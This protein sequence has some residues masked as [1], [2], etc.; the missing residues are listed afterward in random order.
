MKTSSAK[1]KGRKH[2]Q[3][4]RDEILKRHP[5]LDET[6]V[7]SVSMGAGGE[8]ILLSQAARKFLPVS[9]ECKHRANYAFYKD[10]DQ[11]FSNCPENCEPLLVVRANHRPAVAIIDFE[12]FL[13]HYQPRKVRSRK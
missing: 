4:V 10:Y 9:I 3:Y 2:Q 13:D 1:A 12:Y 7:R 5:T 6:D 11:A 8:D